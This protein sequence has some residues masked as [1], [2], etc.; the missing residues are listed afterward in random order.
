MRHVLDV[1]RREVAALVVSNGS[2]MHS[3]GY[4]VLVHLPYVPMF[5]GR[6]WPRS[7]SIMAVGSDLRR[8]ADR[9]IVPQIMEENMRGL[10]F[11]QGR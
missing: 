2:G 10:V 9:G 1:Y 8:G 7:S 3:T 11:G 4:A 5:A 6:K